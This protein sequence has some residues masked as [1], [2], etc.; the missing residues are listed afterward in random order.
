ME[1][2][3]KKCTVT[4][5]S[6]G[7]FITCWLCDGHAH[8]KCAGFNGRCYDKIA[9]KES[10]LRWSCW[11]CR[12]FDVDFYRLFKEAKNGF[13]NLNNDLGSLVSKV[14]IM[15]EMF[16]NF[17]WPQNLVSSPRRKKAS[18]DGNSD[19]PITPN[20]DN[21]GRMFFSPLPSSVPVVVTPLPN[22]VPTID[23]SARECL[24]VGPISIP[25]AVSD[26]PTSSIS[27]QVVCELDKANPNIDVSLGARQVP[28]LSIDST[29]TSVSAP[30]AQSSLS[31]S[32]TGNLVVVPPRKTIFIS[33]LSPDTSVDKIVNFIKLNFSEFN[34]KD[35]KVFK[36]NY[37][38]PRDISSFRIIVP[39]KVFDV[40]IEQSFWPE[41]VLVR[42]FI[43]RNMPRR[44]GPVD[45]QHSKN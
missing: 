30:S 18:G 39:R 8:I 17:T 19:K 35:C 40:L 14:K 1:C 29:G 7:C 37:S 31:T 28:V 9:S 27:N 43:P 12:Q 38:E 33:R 32:D 41:G 10:G 16:I 15:E 13:S 44:V 11:N 5:S 34:D 22:S 24:D 45:L 23:H 36:F 4:S 2:V 6:D 20:F 26:I 42:E 3:A 25:S 21:L